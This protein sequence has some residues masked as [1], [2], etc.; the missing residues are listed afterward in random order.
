MPLYFLKH[1]FIN[2]FFLS[3][4]HAALLMVLLFIYLEDGLDIFVFPL[5]ALYPLKPKQTIQS[6]VVCKGVK[7]GVLPR[8][9]S[10]LLFTP[11]FFS[12][13][14]QCVL[15]FGCHFLQLERCSHSHTVKVLHFKGASSLLQAWRCVNLLSFQRE[16][17][18]KNF[19][20]TEKVRNWLVK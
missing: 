8:E 19:S 1:L 9:Y 14:R 6:S 12:S 10:F 3:F 11:T 15:N 4:S 17:L 7:R 5:S 13:P 16:W 20:G 18:L 2:Y